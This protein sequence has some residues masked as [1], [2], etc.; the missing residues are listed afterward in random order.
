MLDK[1]PKCNSVDSQIIMTEFYENEFGIFPHFSKNHKRPLASVALHPAEELVDDSM[2]EEAI[3]VY[4]KRGIREL[5]DL[6]ITE[7][8]DLPKHVVNLLIK[9][10]DEAGL[11]KQQIAAG[12]EKELNQGKS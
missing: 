3:R 10:S 7:F 4:T 12:I 11:Q 8:L 1:I 9:I 6:S 2:L 5:Y